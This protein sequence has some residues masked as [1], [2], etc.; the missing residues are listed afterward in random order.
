M[1]DNRQSQRQP[2]MVKREFDL[3]V[4]ESNQFDQADHHASIVDITS[5]GVGI[6]SNTPKKP[7]PVLF[8]D[9]IWGQHSGMLLW[10]RQVGALYR[11]GIRFAPLP[12]DAELN[13]NNQFAQ[14]GRE[15]L[16][17][18]TRFVAMQIE[19]IKTSPA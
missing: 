17:D 13:A 8:R 4:F 7:G 18:L 3:G 19:S 2:I 5:S 16:K 6:E 1:D 10:S 14:S 11:S 12:H 9:R 15:P